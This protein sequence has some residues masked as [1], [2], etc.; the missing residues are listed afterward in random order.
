MFPKGIFTIPEFI[1]G[2]ITLIVGQ[3]SFVDHNPLPNVAIFNTLLIGWIA[4]SK[5]GI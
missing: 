1:P 4:I 3:F 2:F 5:T